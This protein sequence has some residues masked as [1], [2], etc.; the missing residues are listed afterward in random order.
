MTFHSQSNP[1]FM[2]TRKVSSERFSDLPKVTQFMCAEAQTRVP[3][4][5]AMSWCSKPCYS[6]AT[7]PMAVGFFSWTPQ[8]TWAAH[9]LQSIL[10]KDFLPHSKKTHT[11]P[12]QG[13]RY[14]RGYPVQ[15]E[16]KINSKFFFS[17]GISC[18]IFGTYLF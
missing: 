15:C 11:P 7:I 14:N 18:S 3:F 1:D 2:Q 10:C 17:A 6:L 5:S 8:A 16:L 9:F 4:C 13:C 12:G